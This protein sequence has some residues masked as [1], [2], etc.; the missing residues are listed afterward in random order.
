[1]HGRVITIGL[2]DSLAGT[3]IQGSV[4]TGHSLGGYVMTVVTAI[5]AQN[6]NTVEA[7][8][9]LPYDL[10]MRQFHAVMQDVGADAIHIGMLPDEETVN[11]IGDVLDEI[12]EMGNFPVVI[13]PVMIN[14]AGH[15]LIDKATKDAIKRR[16][17]IRATVLTPNIYEASCL[18]GLEI[19]AREHMEHAADMLLTLGTQSVFVTGGSL[20][21]D[22]LVDV[23]YTQEGKTMFENPKLQTRNTHGAGTTLSTATAVSLA[24]G[25]TIEE[26]ISVARHYTADA[27][28]RGPNLGTGHA[29]LGH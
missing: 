5:T 20:P 14:S 1:M 23:L 28:K 25:M 13:D 8:Q 21:G 22:T 26:S 7:L 16:L 4:K 10:I 2:S 12:W 18:T 15:E 24:Q 9:P 27:I 29:P 17:L 3:G 6:T 19:T 11:A